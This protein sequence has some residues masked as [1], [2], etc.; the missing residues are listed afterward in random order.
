MTY[1]VLNGV[2]TSQSAG[3][4]VHVND[5]GQLISGSRTGKATLKVTAH[6]DFGVNQ[7]VVILVKVGILGNKKLMA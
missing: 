1:E 7:T 5:A 4:I 2:P 3:I 6:E